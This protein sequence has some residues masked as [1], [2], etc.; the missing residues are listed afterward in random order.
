MAALKEISQNSSINFIHDLLSD[1]KI[2]R[3]LNSID[4]YNQEVL[5]ME[6]DFAMPSERAN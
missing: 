4:D 3:V 5:G 6:T 1:G 2:F